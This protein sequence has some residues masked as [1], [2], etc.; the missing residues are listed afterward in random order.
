[1]HLR[2][3]ELRD[4]RS[5]RHARFEFPE[6][7]GRRN[8]ILVRGP[9]EHGKT[10]LFEAVTLGLFGRDGLSLVPRARAAGRTDGTD[11]LAT[12]YRHFLEGVLHQR[13]IAQGRHNCSVILEFEADGERIEISRTWHFSANG[14]YKPSDDGLRIFEGPERRAVAPPDRD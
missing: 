7:Q 8:V 4:W 3:V 5:Y 2:A 1:M 12:T 9:N 6:P 10:S 11:R 14:Q 13:A